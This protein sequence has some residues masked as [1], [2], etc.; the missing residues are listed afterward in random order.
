MQSERVVQ[1][2]FHAKYKDTKA[3]MLNNFLSNFGKFISA[4]FSG[5][6]MLT[7]P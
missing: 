7:R 5:I 2:M 1:S 4:N 3:N 6:A